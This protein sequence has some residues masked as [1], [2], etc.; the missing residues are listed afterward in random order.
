MWAD[1]LVEVLAHGRFLSTKKHI[2]YTVDYYR[3][4]YIKVV[5]SVVSAFIILHEA[6]SKLF[7][8]LDPS[9]FNLY[10]MNPSKRP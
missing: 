7:K 4:D 8:T 1:W 2:D 5:G 9:S 6:L 10:R 3:I